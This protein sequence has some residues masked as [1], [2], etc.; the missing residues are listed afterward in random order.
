MMYQFLR[1]Y[2]GTEGSQLERGKNASE[3][4]RIC[5]VIRDAFNGRIGTEVKGSLTPN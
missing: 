4:L 1:S 3:S 5:W 2:D